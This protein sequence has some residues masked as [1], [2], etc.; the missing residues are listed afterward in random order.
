MEN[1]TKRSGP[2]KTAD[3]SDRRERELA[4]LRN[5]FEV[6]QKCGFAFIKKIGVD[7]AEDYI[8]YI[9]NLEFLRPRHSE[10]E[11]QR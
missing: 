6:M 4:M 10:K 9:T 3:V 7:S 11:D 8:V 2:S 1:S 5:E